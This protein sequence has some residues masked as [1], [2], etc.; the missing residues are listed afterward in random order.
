MSEVP[1]TTIRIE[2]VDADP[3]RPNPAH[4]GQVARDA[5][6]ALRAEG[7]DVQP[8]Y[9]GAMGGELYELIR[10]LAD[11]AQANKDVVLA[12]I[13]GVAA[14]IATALA[15]RLKK[16]ET[17]AN[18][19]AAPA[20]S[21]AS[22]PVV[23]VVAGTQVEVPDP[24]ISPDDLLRRLLAADPSLPQRV[25]PQTAVTIRAPVMTPPQRPRR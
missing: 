24:Q 9:T 13:A 21:P 2:F 16:A 23:V 8:A 20:T 15:G 25:T 10:T 19:P 3:Q 14:P 7:Y 5:V 11:G 6:A 1:A 18:Q 12:L 4:V 17:P 22:P